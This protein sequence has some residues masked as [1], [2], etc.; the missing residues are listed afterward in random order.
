MGLDELFD[1][2]D[3]DQTGS[4]YEERDCIDSDEEAQLYD[5]L[6]NLMEAQERA[7]SFKGNLN[8]FMANAFQ[9]CFLRLQELE[10]FF[11]LV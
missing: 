5:E 3:A 4:L 11:K 8:K 9:K 7:F 2:V 6:D 1:A 10:D